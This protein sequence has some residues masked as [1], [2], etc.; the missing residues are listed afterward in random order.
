MK[1]K[2]I[3][4]CSTNNI[5]GA[6]QNSV[7]FIK[8]IFDNNSQSEWFFILSREFYLQVSDIIIEDY[9]IFYSPAKS[10]I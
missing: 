9:E 6:I 1:K 8:N 10:F 3:F 4:N 2:Y 7:N 5:G